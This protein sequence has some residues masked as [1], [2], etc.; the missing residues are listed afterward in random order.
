MLHSRLTHLLR[1]FTCSRTL[2]TARWT[3]GCG[4]T[5]RLSERS[6]GW[7][8]P[9]R[10]SVVDPIDWTIFK[11]RIFAREAAPI[12]RD[13]TYGQRWSGLLGGWR[14]VPSERGAP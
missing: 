9:S 12:S 5:R 4:L 2:R 6:M 7:I 11:G 3:Y 14:R 1:F 10:R 13:F 8:H